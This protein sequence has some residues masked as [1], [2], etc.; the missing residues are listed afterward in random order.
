MPLSHLF[1]FG[2]RFIFRRERAHRR[3]RLR[4]EVGS[5]AY[6]YHRF[7]PARLPGGQMEQG[8]GSEAHADGLAS[9]NAQMI[10]HGEYVESQL[11]KRELPGWIRGSSVAS[12]VRNNQP[13]PVGRRGENQV[14]V[15]ADAAP[16]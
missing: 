9:F 3:A 8:F 5:R 15:R 4:R 13:I 1:P 16:A 12:K 10:E 2:L 7:D 14:P 11:S 6:Q